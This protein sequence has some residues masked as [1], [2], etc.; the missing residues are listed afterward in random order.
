MQYIICA[1][2]NQRA[3]YDSDSEFVSYASSPTCSVRHICRQTDWYPQ[4]NDY[5]AICLIND[6][7]AVQDQP[8]CGANDS[9]RERRNVESLHEVQRIST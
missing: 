1:A 4:F 3:F 2:Q 7:A 6:E 5:S 8:E 9:Y